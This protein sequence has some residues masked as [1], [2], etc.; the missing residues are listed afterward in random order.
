M[1]VNKSKAEPSRLVRQLA[2]S[3]GPSARVEGFPLPIVRIDGDATSVGIDVSNA[4]TP[5]R[6]YAAEFCFAEE[7]AGELRFIFAQGALVGDE[8]DSALIVRMNPQAA[9]LMVTSIAGMKAPSLTEIADAM[10]LKAMPLAPINTRPRQM[11]M[12]VASFGAT[13]ISGYDTCIDFYRTSPFAM[14]ELSIT[15]HLAVEP[16]IRVDI[17]TGQFLSLVEQMKQIVATFP[18]NALR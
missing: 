3:S 15:N 1:G 9:G 4:P 5:D 18:S 11:A 10:Q 17:R 12:A 16:V 14:R 8:L 7:K 6:E 13:A 2:K